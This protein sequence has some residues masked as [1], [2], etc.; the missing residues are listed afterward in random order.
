MQRVIPLTFVLVLF[1]LLLGDLIN[2]KIFVKKLITGIALFI[3]LNTA[4]FAE[5]LQMVTYADATVPQAVDIMPSGPSVGDM[6]V[7]HGS[8]RSS[9]GGP[10]IAEFFTTATIINI[11]DDL[12][13]SAR[14]FMVEEVYPD[15]SIYKMDFVQTDHGGLVKEGQQHEG[16]IIGGTGKYAGILGSYSLEILDDGIAKTTSTYWL[17]Q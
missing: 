2:G 7:R 6:Y 5:P 12:E 4:A 16:A 15:G 13:K 3:G 14:S 10:V 1:I 9:I 17:G 8:L 11:S